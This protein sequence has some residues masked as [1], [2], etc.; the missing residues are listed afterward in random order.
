MHLRNNIL[1]LNE[2]FLIMAQNDSNDSSS[3]ISSLNT[4]LIKEIITVLSDIDN[5]INSLHACSSSDFLNLNSQLKNF[6]AQAK[7]LFN[8]ASEISKIIE[9]NENINYFDELD[10]YPKKI[11]NLLSLYE[12]QFEYYKSIFEKILHH[13]QYIV[14][15]FKNFKQNIMTLKFLVANLNLNIT[16]LNKIN[17]VAIDNESNKTIDLTANLKTFY[18]IIDENIDYLLNH[19]REN[20]KK[21]KSLIDNSFLNIE[22]II[23]QIQSSISL[24][25]VKHEKNI[26]AI[27]RFRDKTQ[28]CND[29]IGKIIINLQYHDIIRQKM[30]H[31]RETLKE[32]IDELNII[33]DTD[34][35]GLLQA[36]LRW[37][38]QIPEITE[39]QVAQLIYTNQEY[40]TA[41]ENI[42]NHFLNIGEEMSMVSDMNR[43]LFTTKH[44]SEESH[45]NDLN[46]KINNSNQLICDFIKN[47]NNFKNEFNKITEIIKNISFY[48]DKISN[49][50]KDLEILA[51]E[52]V[53]KL[54]DTAQ[55]HEISTIAQQIQELCNNMQKIIYDIKKHLIDAAIVCE[56]I[57]TQ[58]EETNINNQ[59]I[60]PELLTNA[61]KKIIDI[62]YKQNKMVLEKINNN[63]EIFEKISNDIK[64][65]IEQVKYYDFFEKNIEEIVINLNNV[66]LKLRAESQNTIGKQIN[67]KHLTKKY[68][69]Q[70]EHHVHNQHILK[71]SGKPESEIKL[72]EKKTIDDNNIGD[73]E[74]F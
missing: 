26:L 34:E 16:Y 72:D 60:N 64:Q 6:H 46:N 32:I 70:S 62:L 47:K 49:I 31:I 2:I 48:F 68:T 59:K 41:I 51:A 57:K 14:V 30:E 13:L 55:E 74:L 8:N 37:A 39:L 65:S 50:N 43:Q 7:S 1:Y 17:T 71:Y 5:R 12:K 28:Q 19:I 23:S 27:S 18:P 25:F 40:Q 36:K 9:S 61:V 3:L 21:I 11:K 52:I 63:T 38:N 33:K 29:D 73:V 67:L 69:T 10:F 44:R 15:P 66:Y 45:F 54:K 42:T 35:E 53:L 20:N 22:N 24:L 58:N 56:E 4:D